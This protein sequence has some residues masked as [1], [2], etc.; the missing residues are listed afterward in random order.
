L[1]DATPGAAAGAATTLSSQAG[2]RRIGVSLKITDDEGRRL[3]HDRQAA[4]HLK[5]ADPGSPKRITVM[6]GG[7]ILDDEG[8]FDTGDVATIDRDGYM[9]ITDRPKT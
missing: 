8:Y 5:V 2:S 9:Q 3:E 1:P 6:K 7:P 4:G